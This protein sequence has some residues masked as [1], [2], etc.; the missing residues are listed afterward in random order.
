MGKSLKLP[1]NTISWK[2]F[3]M[4]LIS[5]VFLPGLFQIFWLCLILNKVYLIFTLFFLWFWHTS[6]RVMFQHKIDFLLLLYHVICHSWR[7]MDP[8]KG[9]KQRRQPAASSSLSLILYI[10]KFNITH[11]VFL[12]WSLSS[13]RKKKISF[14]EMD[15][16]ILIGILHRWWFSL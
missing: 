4:Y 8:L 7:V 13:P 9:Q 11:I 10:L 1:K 3:S 14:K 5:R 15:A 12:I 6:S 2:N 16:R